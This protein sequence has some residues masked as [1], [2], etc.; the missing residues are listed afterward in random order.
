[1]TSS[2]ALSGADRPKLPSFVRMQ[3]DRARERWVLQGPE[4]VLVIDDTGKEILE[5]ADGSATVD[6]II[7]KLVAEYDAPEDIIR[8]D[9]TAVLTLLAEKNFLEL[10]DGDG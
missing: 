2:S 5:R 6:E 3:Y 9:V 10:E 8:Q 4:R 7:A 1:M